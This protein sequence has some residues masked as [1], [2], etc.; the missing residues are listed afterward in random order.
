MNVLA[1][2]PHDDDVELGAGGFVARLADEGWHITHLVLEQCDHGEVECAAH[3]LGIDDLVFA[4]LPGRHY[5]DCRQIIL[6]RFIQIRDNALPDLVL[7]P[8]PTDIHQ[9]HQVTAQE[10][11][12][13]FKHT[14][15]LGYNMVWNQLAGVPPAYFVTL[16]GDQLVRKI[17][18]LR[19]YSRNA[20]YMYNVFTTARA[21]V[22]GLQAGVAYAEA[23]E[24]LRW[25][26]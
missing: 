24:V 6:E 4:E 18:A 19:C 2:S 21:V 7:V 5:L 9:D 23:F 20:P 22:C 13:A 10:A 25:I 15:I 8:R 3:I 1:I 26:R 11:L 12:R 14:C 17:R 16:G